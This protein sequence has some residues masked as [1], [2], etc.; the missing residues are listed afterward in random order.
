MGIFATQSPEDALRSDISAALI[1][2]T[3][4]MILLPNPNADK[5]DYIEGLK[6]TEAE[7]NVIVNLDERSRCFLVK[8]GHSSAVCQL[9]L[10]GMDDV[11]SVISASTDN[12]EIMQRIIRENASRLGISVN[13]ITP[14]QWL[15]DFYDQRKGSRS[16]Q[17]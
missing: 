10:R 6:L 4:T 1:E 8:Q 11:L 15:Q 2:Q 12:I 13:Q 16:K 7:F 14:E 3:A 9:N 17:T 5:K